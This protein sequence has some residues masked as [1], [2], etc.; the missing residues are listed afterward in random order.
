M[1]VLGSVG[2]VLLTW[3]AK[4]GFCLNFAQVI[5]PWV[6]LLGKSDVYVAGEG[7]GEIRLGTGVEWG[8]LGCDDVGWEGKGRNGKINK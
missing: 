1:R 6:L 2:V 8:C 5:I 3:R 4:E 7:K